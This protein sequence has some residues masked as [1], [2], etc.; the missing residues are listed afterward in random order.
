M[1]DK[2]KTMQKMLP[3]FALLWTVP[4]FA[5]PF[6]VSSPNSASAKEIKLQ[7]ELKDA[8][9]KRKM[10][11]PKVELKTPVT[12]HLDFAI[13]LPVR[14]VDYKHGPTNG[15]IGD[16]EL[17]SRWGFY[18]SGAL[19]LATGLKM[20]F[21]SGDEDRGLG[22][23]YTTF[24]IPLI[25]GYSAGDWTLGSELGYERVL[26]DSEQSAY[27]GFLLERKVLPSLKLGTEIVFESPDAKFHFIDT[28]ADVGLKWKLPEHYE[29]QA[30]AGRSL[31]RHESGHTA[32]FKLAIEK[33][34]P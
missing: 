19:G 34:F 4:A 30:L 24:E 17:K 25:I 22:A 2:R 8:P 3:L 7:A 1:I 14:V 29:L 33:T 18:R 16:V 28:R 20:T 12:N 10:T 5:G 23:G 31:H 32:T 6:T 9:A 11:L 15:G 21:P 26:H 27:W 13:E